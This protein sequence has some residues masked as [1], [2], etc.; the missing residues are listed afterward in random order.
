[1][2]IAGVVIVILVIGAVVVIGLV[3]YFGRHITTNWWL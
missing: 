1:M 3:M 2:G